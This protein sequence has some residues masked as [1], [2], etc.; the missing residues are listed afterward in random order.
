MTQKCLNHTN[1][2][3]L[4]EQMRGEAVPQR[5][6]QDALLDPR[7]LRGGVDGTTKLAGRQRFDRVAAG[8]Q[9]ASR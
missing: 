8:K 5:M 4:F 6:W 9:P 2:D 7:G 1:I 3:I